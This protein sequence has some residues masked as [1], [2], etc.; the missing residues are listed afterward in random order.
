MYRRAVLFRSPKL[1]GEALNR[2]IVAIGNFDGVHRGHASVIERAVAMA[3]HHD[4]DAA[5]LT[6]DPHPVLY[7]RPET[8]EFRL[9]SLEQKAAL[10]TDLGLQA[11]VACTFDATLAGLAPDEFVQSILVDALHVSAVLVGSDFRFGKGRAGD[12]DTLRELGREHGF[13][14]LTVPLESSDA[15]VISSTRV[16]QALIAGEL[17]VVA[18]LLGRPYTLTG[19]VE[20]GDALGRTFGF[21][22]ANIAP[23]NPLLP[24]DGIYA[25]RLRTPA[26]G[27]YVAATYIGTRPAISAGASRIV[28]AYCLDA[29]EEL[30][31]YGA[32]VE[33]EFVARVREDRD[34]ASHDALIAQMHVDVAQVR[35]I[36][37]G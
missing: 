8:P 25:T 23:E 33:L 6:F 35:A 19:T 34:F 18:R 24:A 21:P 22:T 12:V 4:V 14:V 1:A 3:Q 32:H 29:P 28:E 20:G 17:D 16:R 11:V 9:T 27:D 30:D 26:L 31:L 2:P 13:Q 5:V 37:E 36:S 15:E 7:F 10:L